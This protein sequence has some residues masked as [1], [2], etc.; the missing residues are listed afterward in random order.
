MALDKRKAGEAESA[1]CL[2]RAIG[3]SVEITL[4][5]IQQVKTTPEV[6]P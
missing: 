3:A 6:C 1:D 5:F 2:D 4:A